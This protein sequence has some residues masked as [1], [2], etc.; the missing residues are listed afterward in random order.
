MKLNTAGTENRITADL[1]AEALRVLPAVPEGLLPET[2]R[3]AVCRFLRQAEPLAGLY[4]GESFRM[5]LARGRGR[6]P[7]TF[8]CVTPAALLELPGNLILLRV[9]VS[10]E[11]VSVTELRFLPANSGREVFRER[12]G[13]RQA[14]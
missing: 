6:K 9:C 5:R 7:E 13:R 4:A 12:R 14:A 10:P 3:Y 2:L 1:T 11:L 8:T